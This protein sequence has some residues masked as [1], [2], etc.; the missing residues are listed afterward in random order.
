[1]KTLTTLFG[2]FLILLSTTLS[3]QSNIPDYDNWQAHLD[4]AE[5]ALSSQNYKEAAIQYKAA[6]AIIDKSLYD[7]PAYM[8]TMDRI[9]SEHHVFDTATPLSELLDDV[10]TRIETLYGKSHAVSIEMKNEIDNGEIESGKIT[11]G[12]VYFTTISNLYESSDKTS[13]Y[14]KPMVKELMLR[15]YIYDDQESI[16]HYAY[17][18]NN[19]NDPEFKEYN[20]IVFEAYY[21]S[22]EFF[23]KSGDTKS[24]L[25][26]LNNAWLFIPENE[27]FY[28]KYAI[29]ITEHIYAINIDLGHIDEAADITEDITTLYNK[30]YG[31]RS[32]KL[33]ILYNNLAT[34]YA[35]IDEYELAEK[36]SKK[37]IVN[38]WGRGD[39][40]HDYYK[41]IRDNYF[42]IA[43][44]VKNKSELLRLYEQEI[45]TYNRLSIKNENFALSL[46]D[47]NR[48]IGYDKS[49][50]NKK[51]ENLIQ[52]IS[53][54]IESN[55]LGTEYINAFFALSNIYSQR[56]YIDKLTILINSNIS[57]L[58]RAQQKSDWEYGEFYSM[59][60]KEYIPLKTNHKDAIL[61]A[62]KAIEYYKNNNTPYI[63]Y[64]D[65]IA[66]KIIK[67]NAGKNSEESL[68]ALRDHISN[69]EL[70]HLKET[71]EYAGALQLLNAFYAHEKSPSNNQSSLTKET[72]E[73][74]QSIGDT[75]S[76]NYNT[77]RMA[78]VRN[79][80][81][82]G[83]NSE[84]AILAIKSY[85][86]LVQNLELALRNKSSSS[87][88]FNINH[89]DS[90]LLLQLQYYNY[91]VQGKDDKLMNTAIQAS[92]LS[93]NLTL[94]ISSTILNQ[95]RE[96][97]N[98][99]LMYFTEIYQNTSYSNTAKIDN[100]RQQQYKSLSSDREQEI[101][102]LNEEIDKAYAK[103]IS[104]YY[105][106][107]NEPILSDIKSEE[108]DLRSNAIYV[109][110]VRAINLDEEVTY[111]A[112]V[113]SPNTDKPIVIELGTEKQ[114]KNMLSSADIKHLAYE[115]R[116]SISKRGNSSTMGKELYDVLWSPISDEIGSP[117]TVYFS[118]TGVLNTIPFSSLQDEQGQI[119]MDKYQL[120]Q[121][122]SSA[123]L[124]SKETSSPDFSDIVIYGGINYDMNTDLQLDQRFNYLPGTME[125]TTS[126]K[127]IIPEAKSYTG[128][129]ANEES[130]R[131]LDGNSPSILH[132]AT[133]GFYF[134]YDDSPKS[135]FGK[136]LKM[137][138]DPLR[139]TGLILANGN[140]GINGVQDDK[141]ING[142]EGVLT[143]L[144][145][146]LLNLAKTDLVVLSAC[147]TGLGDI[148]G[149]EGVYGLQRA[150]KLAGAKMILMSLWEIPDLETKEFMTKFYSLCLSNTVRSAFTSAQ[151]YMKQ[152][153]PD[154]PEIWAAFILVE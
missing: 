71:E 18:W 15:A 52:I 41:T 58:I 7:H 139:R 127:A 142:T 21:K 152:Q 121:L 27:I 24:R 153:Y 146:T 108:F 16:C 69:L 48:L 46:I 93:K 87:R 110:Y 129:K 96:Y 147:E 123:S 81:M 97:E 13:L 60:A 76:A 113:Y 74:Y 36:Y 154:K 134:D 100:L 43:H 136:V 92:H 40:D 109:D 65:L 107:N 62:N 51:I 32:D 4:L 130:F 31:S 106:N 45:V 19:L 105:K 63:E 138:K 6:K 116:G 11:L 68:N 26:C 99:S 112:Y 70:Y 20:Q 83:M 114:L 80:F 12:Q 118:L 50:E 37:S 151:Q 67:L 61:Y 73:T 125:E 124:V 94:G 78:H 29:S 56:E 145:I 35:R 3:S 132:I 117:S 149:S 103:L 131:S 150:F 44:N 28:K 8:V 98:A 90:K 34:A 115:T 84:G 137:D 111:L 101:S 135:S 30:Y 143:S 119:L 122:V 17:N 57:T 47:Q 2:V 91:I 95:L 1:M 39:L 66:I 9:I 104:T 144:E 88:D 148:N 14:I 53:Y 33:I 64:A 75:L 38:F 55:T 72:I 140:E 86:N 126:I 120:R 79:L 54:Y 82:D 85:N 49:N 5:D 42:T 141:F 59:I 128:N 89:F 25:I 102:V 22:S 77:A 133:H 10:Q 23:H